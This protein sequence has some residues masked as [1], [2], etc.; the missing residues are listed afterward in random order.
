M[1]QR[2]FT[3]SHVNYEMHFYKNQIFS[4][5]CR[6]SGYSDISSNQQYTHW[7]DADG[8]V[9]RQSSEEQIDITAAACSGHITLISLIG[10][11]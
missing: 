9:K 6:S 7:I 1:L 3:D 4:F 10:R 11:L 5:C 2:P 8:H